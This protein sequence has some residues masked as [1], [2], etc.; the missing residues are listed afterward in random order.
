M[1]GHIGIDWFSTT[2]TK[3]RVPVHVYINCTQFSQTPKWM[4]E[5]V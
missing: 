5:S 2:D 3:Q 1:Q 4:Y